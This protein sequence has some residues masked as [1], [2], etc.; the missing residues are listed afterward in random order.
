M[1]K[2]IIFIVLF[3]SFAQAQFYE[4]E[5]EMQVQTHYTEKGLKFFEEWE[6]DPKDRQIIIDMNM[7]PP[8]ENYKFMFNENYSSS[9]HIAKVNN[10]QEDQHISVNKTAPTFGKNAFIDYKE[11]KF[12]SQIDV[13]GDK[14]LAYDSIHKISFEDTGK[15]KEILGIQVKEAIG[16][17]GKYDL[18]NWYALSI[19][20]KFSP[21]IFYCAKGLILELHYKYKMSDEGEILVS[22]KA[23]KIK[24]LN[25]SLKLVK[26]NKGKLVKY[27]D[28]NKIYEEANNKR[29][30]M[31]NQ[32]ESTKNKLI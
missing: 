9:N 3:S 4:I 26:P 2:L 7:N 11:N 8:I 19:N 31:Y 5:Y 25:K 24:D 16:K 29:N 10:S 12:W 15:M 23:T 21:D 13:Y 14:Y 18:I 17:I 30:A 27:T 20:Y 1:K 6:K 28:L 32:E 22:W